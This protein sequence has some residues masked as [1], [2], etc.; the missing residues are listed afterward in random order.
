MLEMS[1]NNININVSNISGDSKIDDKIIATFNANYSTG[2]MA[3]FS[4]SKNV[5]NM[6]LY[7][8]NTEIIDSDYANFECE[9]KKLV[10]KLANVVE[11]NI[12]DT[13]YSAEVL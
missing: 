1:T 13:E 4:I 3:N 5:H 11:K 9:I 6:D 10:L 7:N 8:A 12:S 2:M